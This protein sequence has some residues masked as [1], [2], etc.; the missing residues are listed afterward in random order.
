MGRTLRTVFLTA[1]LLGCGGNKNQNHS[2]PVGF[3]NQTR[4][5]DADLWTIWSLAQK[6][7]AAQV[8][9]NPVQQTAENAPPLILPG[10]SRSLSVVP[11]QLT[12]APQPD[13]SSSVLAAAGI[14][15]STPTGMIACPPPCNV[16]YTTA[17]SRY[18]TRTIYAASWES[19]DDSFRTILEYEFENQILF[20]LGYDMS[21]R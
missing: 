18:P 17:Y 5:S 13:L 12:V 19:S 3:L 20:A 1:L 2:A 10:D 4:H 16:R 6:N 15:R 8:N 9:L 7:V 11:H 21:W 14:Q